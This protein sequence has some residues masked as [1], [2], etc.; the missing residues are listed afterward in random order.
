MRQDIIE[1]TEREL[2]DTGRQLVVSHMPLAYAMAWRMKDCGIGQEDL[3]QE[4]SLGLCEAAMRY[5]E[6]CN[7]SFATYARHW[8]RKMMLMAIHHNTSA[9]SLHDETFQELEDE[10]L[11]RS[12]QLRRIDDALVCL[13]HRER[14]IVTQHYG[15]GTERLSITEIAQ[16]Q[17]FSKARA[18]ALHLRALKK[19]ETALRNH[20]LVDYLTPWIE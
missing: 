4:A 10:D 15:L 18:S 2:T 16:A 3:R 17:G 5:D 7:C 1:T 6:S 12:G 19:L 13:T 11:L 14:L 8:C 20:P 9:D